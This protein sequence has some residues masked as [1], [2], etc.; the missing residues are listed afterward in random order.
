[1]AGNTD[2]PQDLAAWI[3]RSTEQEDSIAPGLLDRFAAVLDRSGTPARP[4]DAAPPLAHWLLFLSDTPQSGLGPDGH[5]ARGGFLPP[6]HDLPRRMWAGGRLQFHAPLRAGEALRRRSVIKAIE[7]R[8]GA[9]GPLVF[10]TLRHEIGAAAGGPTLLTE[11]HDIV[12]RGTEGAAVKPAPEAPRGEWHRSLVP[13]AVLLFRYSALT[14]NGH[15]I[16][17]DRDYVTTIEGYPGL[18]VHGPLT[19]TLL[20][21]LVRRQQPEGRIAAFSFRAVSPLFD[22]AAMHLNATPPDAEGR[23][24]LWATNDTGRLAMRGEARLG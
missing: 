7:R 20:L 4:G 13:D 24:A 3:G 17:Y 6:V 19:A 11:E 23:I 15:R 21:D 1:M 14:F 10:V 22:G 16:H 2:A 18:I 8:E 12:Y 5:P 9:S